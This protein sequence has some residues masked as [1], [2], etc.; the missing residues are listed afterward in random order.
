M[1]S[2]N[3]GSGLSGCQPSTSLDALQ[4]CPLCPQARFFKGKRGLNVHI[5]KTHKPQCAVPL[6]PTQTNSITDTSTLEPFWKRLSKFKNNSNT[7]AGSPR[8][9]GSNSSAFGRLCPPGC[10]GELATCLGGLTHLPL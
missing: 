6:T 4:R 3:D 8:R 9:Q 5:G 2:S 7:E 1:S 10:T